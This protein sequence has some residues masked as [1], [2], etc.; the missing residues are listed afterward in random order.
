MD[1]EKKK[2]SNILFNMKSD[3]FSLKIKPLLEI[4]V[5]QWSGVCRRFL[6][7]ISKRYISN[8]SWPIVIKFDVNLKHHQEGGK[9]A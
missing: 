6:F 9:A 4:L 2:N 5:W 8:V 3:H 7:T 1:V